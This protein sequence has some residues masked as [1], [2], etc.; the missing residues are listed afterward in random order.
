MSRQRKA[1]VILSDVIF[2]VGDIPIVEVKLNPPSST[3][4]L[5]SPRDESDTERMSDPHLTVA[6]SHPSSAVELT[7]TSKQPRPSPLLSPRPSPHPSPNAS[8]RSSPRPSPHRHTSLSP[9][10]PLCSDSDSSSGESAYLSCSDPNV[11]EEVEALN[12]LLLGER[13]SRLD[14][15]INQVHTQ[16]QRAFDKLVKRD[17]IQKSRR[18]SYNDSFER[19]HLPHKSEKTDSLG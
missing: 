17:R 10:F 13:L 1:K 4:S 12:T 11:P 15:R 14:I 5:P 8:S 19:Q 18:R 9:C 16:S 6:Q 2:T 7:H 3:G